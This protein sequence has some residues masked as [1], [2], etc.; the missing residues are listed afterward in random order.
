M[1]LLMYACIGTAFI[2]QTLHCILRY[3][4]TD[5]RYKESVELSRQKRKDRIHVEPTA[6]REHYSD[7][8]CQSTGFTFSRS[9]RFDGYDVHIYNK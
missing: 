2:D 7:T 8:I 9:N 5:I 3:I 6:Q 4:W 1:P